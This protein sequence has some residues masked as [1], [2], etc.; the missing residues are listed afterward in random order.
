MPL[1]ILVI[2]SLICA[3]YGLYMGLKFDGEKERKAR[4]KKGGV[5]WK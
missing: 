1:A 5:K 2:P 4:K 3:L